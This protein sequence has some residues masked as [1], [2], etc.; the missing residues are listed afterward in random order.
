MDHPFA[1]LVIKAVLVSYASWGAVTIADLGV[2][3]TRTPG[4]C[5]AQRSEVKGAAMA[6]STTLLAWLVDSPVKG[7]ISAA[8]RKTQF[9]HREDTREN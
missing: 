1:A 7:A 4:R 8:Q 6:I 3:E 9:F 5:E 2:C